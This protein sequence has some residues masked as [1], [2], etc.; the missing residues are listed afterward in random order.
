MMGQDGEAHQSI[1][2]YEDSYFIGY[3]SYQQVSRPF[4]LA[5]DRT[6]RQPL[7]P[8]RYLQHMPPLAS[9]ILLPEGYR[10]A[11]R[12]VHIVKRSGRVAH[13]PPV[14]RSF[15]GIGAK[16]ELQREADEMLHQLCTTQLTYPFGAYW[17]H[18]AHI[19]M[20]WSK[21]L[22]RLELILLPPPPGGAD[23]F[24]NS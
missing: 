11:H 5:P 20:H 23:S 9:F 16:K 14:D 17:P 4:R 13:P 2:F 21:P 10:P 24:S 3:T 18:L 19:E 1:S 7:V 12:D 22:A 15:A 6:P 8:P